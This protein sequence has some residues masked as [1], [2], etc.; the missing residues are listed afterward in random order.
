MPNLKYKLKRKPST[1]MHA[2]VAC[3]LVSFSFPA[4][5]LEE[6]CHSFQGEN[7][8][9]VDS[10][11]MPGGNGNS[12]KTAYSELSAALMHASNSPNSDQIWI[13]QGEYTGATYDLVD[14]TAL[15]GGFSGNEA[16]ANKRNPKHYKTI[17]TANSSSHHV[18]FANNVSNASLV[19]LSVM[20]GAATGD[21]LADDSDV[22]NE[23]R[24]GGLL[25]YNSEITLCD[26]VFKENSAKKFGGAIY[27]EGGTLT[28]LNSNFNHNEVLRGKFVIHNTIDLGD[29]DGGA[30]AI[31]NAFLRVK[32]SIFVDNLSGDDGAG[33]AG[34]RVNV[35]IDG[36]IF[37]RNKAIAVGVALTDPTF[38]E[39][40]VTST[41]GAISIQ[42]EYIGSFAG[43]QS[44]KV[45]IRNSV[46]KDNKSPVAAGLFI[47]GTPGSK[48]LIENTRFLN[49]GG[50][51]AVTPDSPPNEV[52]VRFGR[53]AAA[54]LLT[55]AR[56]GDRELDENN[57]FVRSVHNAKILN[58][59]FSNNEAGHGGAAVLVNSDTIIDRTVF[60][61]NTANMRGGAIWNQNFFALSDLVSGVAFEDLDLGTTTITRSY[62]Y[63]NKVRGILESIQVDSFPSLVT[64]EE[65]TFGGGAISNDQLGILNISNTIFIGNE[66]I[67]SD[68]GAIQNASAPIVFY[69][70]VSGPEFYPANLNVKNSLFFGNTTTGEGSGGAISNGGNQLNGSVIDPGGYD[71]RAD[72]DA[73][74]LTI[75]RSTFY[76]NSAVNS[77]G[78]IA[79]W[80]SSSLKIKHS[81]IKWNSASTGGG[82]SV[83]GHE[84]NQASYKEHGTRFANN[85]ANDNDSNDI[86]IINA[87]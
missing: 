68:G 22:S 10:G 62:F 54:L 82:I 30:I 41:G 83:I 8:I 17:L 81:T 55:N 70:Q 18:L 47:M 52:G 16:S 27:S 57:N 84:E 85:A 15:I 59:Y 42:N 34:R 56:G 31:H 38:T 76:A 25:A 61:S 46:I 2:A 44:Y 75:N 1:R 12:W 72:V 78:A 32:N 71:R 77:G 9:Y 79:N 6:V 87:N 63:N 53:G 73:A 67:N 69:A 20:G 39:G 43:D 40:L 23:V 50:S 11:A 51:G 65:Q 3:M 14:D 49:N 86:F 33:I 28:V 60:D 13:S 36:S 80:N 7:I 66:A 5:S 58:S 48:T 45:T 35:K 24:G 37:K 74:I 19:S 4:Y 21:L 26:T 29:T 64:N